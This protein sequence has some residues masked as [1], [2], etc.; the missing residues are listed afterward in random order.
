M[1][2]SFYHLFSFK[3]GRKIDIW[4]TKQADQPSQ[5]QSINSVESKNKIK[6]NPSQKIDTLQSV[7]I[8]DA[9]SNI[10]NDQEVFG[11]Y[12][13]ADYDFNLNMWSTTKADDVRASLKRIKKIKLYQ[14]IIIS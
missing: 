8:E 6:I 12:D 10:E 4:K 3:R 11:I 5:N 7:K 13:P 1:E 9:N 2:Y 14:T